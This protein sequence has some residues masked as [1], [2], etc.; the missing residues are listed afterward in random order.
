VNGETRKTGETGEEG[1]EEGR[2]GGR[3]GRGG[4]E[5]G[6]AAAGGIKKKGS[7]MSDSL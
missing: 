5:D 6:G 1:R 4:R 7:L 3:K 2:K